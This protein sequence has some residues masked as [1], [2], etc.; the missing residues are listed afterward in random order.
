[1]SVVN[2]QAVYDSL[3]C[4]ALDTHSRELQYDVIPW[5]DHPSDGKRYG[6][7]SVECEHIWF[8]SEKRRGQCTFTKHRD[9]KAK[10][11]DKNTTYICSR[12]AER[13]KPRKALQEEGLEAATIAVS[14]HSKQKKATAEAP[15]RSY[16]STSSFRRV[17]SNSTG[18]GLTCSKCAYKMQLIVFTAQPDRMIIVLTHSNHTNL[19]GLISHGPGSGERFV[20]AKASEQ[21]HNYILEQHRAGVPNSRILQGSQ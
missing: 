12:H 3:E 13:R 10:G 17:G 16:M 20:K 7:I 2:L 6:C 1:M 21:T 4:V 19:E 9:L 15:E 5:F 18:E 14:Q 11:R 8:E